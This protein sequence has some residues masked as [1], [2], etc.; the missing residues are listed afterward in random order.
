[1]EVN[2]KAHSGMS[3]E[4]P[5]PAST[6][7]RTLA[8]ACLILLIGL[9]VGT[10]YSLLKIPPEMILARLGI[11]LSAS[12]GHTVL[13]VSNWQHVTV[14][15]L[16]MLPVSCVAYALFSARS[17]FMGFAR[18]EYFSLKTVKCIRGFA[19]GIFTSGMTGL[20]SPPLIGLIL[21]LNAPAGTRALAINVGSHELLML[22]IGGIMW[23][24]SNVM[25]RAAA[26]AEENSQFI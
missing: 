4:D 20:I 3:T 19:V 16:G 23:Q 24:I 8:S 13:S 10:L 17:V 22:L 5:I 6:L 11:V 21:T 18:G 15:A 2:A 14:T 1:M 9:L 7:N 26:L 12:G 25:A